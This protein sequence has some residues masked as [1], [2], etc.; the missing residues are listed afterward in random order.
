M[1]DSWTASLADTACTAA[2]QLGMWLFN[3][4]QHC[5]TLSTA[6]C[7][8]SSPFTECYTSKDPSATMS[9]VPSC[10]SPEADFSEGEGLASFDHVRIDQQVFSNGQ[11]RKK[12]H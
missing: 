9:E 12:I 8:F 7:H 10:C 2:T 3:L 4:S 6:K 1:Q 11:R 5:V